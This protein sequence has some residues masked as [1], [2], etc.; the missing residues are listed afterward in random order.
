MAKVKT[1]VQATPKTPQTPP[2]DGAE[3][4]TGKASFRRCALTRDQLPTEALI[5]F[6]RDPDGN[7]VPDVKATLPGRGVWIGLEG[8]RV[9]AAVERGVF[10]RAFK[11]P[12]V[13]SPSLADQVLAQLQARALSW[14][15]LANK[16]GLVVQGFD[17]VSAAIAK[18]RVAVLVAARDGSEDGRGKLR[19][20]LRASGFDADVVEDYESEQLGLALGR[21]NVIHAAMNA[22]ALT[23]RFV[24]QTRRWKAYSG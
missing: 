6:A 10:P 19:Q 16:A 7:V 3:P 4:S 13:V 12:C 17:K 1:M 9:K 11:A 8:A 2:N 22:G 15:S 23:S 20:R 24:A 14:L 18:G 21:T 5:R